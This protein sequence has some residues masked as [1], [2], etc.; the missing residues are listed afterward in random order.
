MGGDFTLYRYMK[1]RG[2]HCAGAVETRTLTTVL[3]GPART[4]LSGEEAEAQRDW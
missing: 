3:G 2:K 4:Q 1:G